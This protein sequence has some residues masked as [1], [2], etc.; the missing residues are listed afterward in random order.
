MQSHSYDPMNPF[1]ARRAPSARTAQM[2]APLAKPL[3]LA[4][5]GVVP[6][7]FLA[8]LGAS[9]CDG[10]DKCG[11]GVLDPGETC[12]GTELQGASC[13]SLGYATG[14]LGCADD[15]SLDVSDCAG[16]IDCGNGVLDSGEQCDGS[17]LDGQSCEDLDLGGGTLA[18]D[19]VTCQLDV[20]GCEAK[21]ICGDGI[22]DGLEECDGE[23]LRGADC[24]NV[25]ATYLG[26]ELSCSPDCTLLTSRCY[27]EPPWPLG[28]P[29]EEDADCPGGGCWA[30]LGDR[31]FGPPGGYCIEPCAGNEC[32][33]TG[34]A[35][36]C[37][38]LY[39][40]YRLCFL[41]CE[42]DD[43][44]ACRPGYTC[45]LADNGED[46]YCYP[47]CTLDDH[48]TTTGLCDK[49]SGQWT[50]GYCLTPDEYCSGG[51]DED[52]DGLVDCADPDCTGETGCPTG[53]ICGNGIDDDGDGYTDCDDAECGTLGICLGQLCS[54]VPGA[55][56]GC[57]D[58]LA[59]ETNDAS[60]STDVIE[61]A[62]CDAPDGGQSPAFTDETGPEYTYTL[63][64]SSPQVVTLTVDNFTGDLDI[65][66]LKPAESGV[67]DPYQRCFAFGGSP[68]DTDEV[69]T[70]AAYPGLSYYVVVDGYQ[71]TITTYDLSVTCDAT[72][73]EDCANNQDDDGDSLVD[74]A[75]PEC[76][77]V[78]GC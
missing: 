60:G 61:G 3:A 75:D 54:P 52:F 39:G 21:G 36:I 63:T 48:C 42:L 71:D 50:E 26:G 20:T 55:T 65:Y 53:E 56:L 58:V 2:A 37:Q 49:D 6:L 24:T 41:R 44:T 31:G 13:R 69:V 34:P 28:A 10:D 16:F 68:P 19:P 12:D 38:A 18:C 17:D 78:G 59:G 1:S 47:D 30:E 67:C 72:G 5:A 45:R 25:D 73:Y 22:A 14:E 11:N 77:H 15:C 43:P 7:F 66:V 32:T 76:Q 35:G 70:F 4:L 33:L 27:G 74:C 9:G 62:R 64:V 57:G 23:D 46:G 29:C 8:A 51:V 40:S